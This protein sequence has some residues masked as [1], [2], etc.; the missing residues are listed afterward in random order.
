[1]IYHYVSDHHYRPPA[2]FTEAIVGSALPGSDEYA[3][4]L[5]AL[6]FKIFEY[7]PWVIDVE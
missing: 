6:D 3:Q 7:G 2:E 4:R 1:M 5:A